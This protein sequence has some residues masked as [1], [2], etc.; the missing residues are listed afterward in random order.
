MTSIF[1]RQSNSPRYAEVLQSIASATFDF[2]A[3]TILDRGEDATKF[4]EPL[5]SLIKA[6]E[7]MVGHVERPTWVNP[8][9][10]V[11][12]NAATFRTELPKP[13]PARPFMGKAEV[14]A[15][16]FDGNEDA[17]DAA[18]RLGFPTASKHQ[19]SLDGNQASRI[20]PLWNP[21]MVEKWL[22][23]YQAARHA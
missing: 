1:H 15:A 7:I 2:A 6:G 3:G 8:R 20:E 14:T 12:I 10:I 23:Q 21:A 11:L 5:E 18:L 13:A 16:Y 22:D 4:P 9:R 19:Y 17:F